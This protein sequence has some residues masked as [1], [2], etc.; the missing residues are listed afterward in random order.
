VKTVQ[1]S[2]RSKDTDAVLL[3]QNR[4]VRAVKFFRGLE[5]FHG[6]VCHSVL[7]INRHQHTAVTAGDSEGLEEGTQHVARYGNV[8]II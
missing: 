1:N 5:T 7:C 4:V 8:G 6:D 2:R 3:T